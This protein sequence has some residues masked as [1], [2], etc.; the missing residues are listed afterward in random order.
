MEIGLCIEM[1][2]KNLPFEDRLRAAGRLGFR[3]VEM[4][5]VD[6]SYQGAPE[7]LAETARE[8]GVPTVCPYVGFDC[9][10]AA[11][12]VMSICGGIQTIPTGIAVVSRPNG[13]GSSHRQMTPPS[14]TGFP[15]RSNAENV[16]TQSRL[17]V[18]LR[19]TSMGKRV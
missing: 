19:L 12:C 7:K 8:A 15:R 5:F 10:A 2:L 18:A 16:R 13:V 11:L 14:P 6:A 4:W 1:A 17:G 9:G 3:N